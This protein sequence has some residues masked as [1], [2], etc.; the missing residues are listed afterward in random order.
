MKNNGDCLVIL[1]PQHSHVA[2]TARAL[3]QVPP[4]AERTLSNSVQAPSSLLILPS[5]SL[6]ISCLVTVDMSC[7]TKGEKKDTPGSNRFLVVILTRLGLVLGPE[8]A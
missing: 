7:Y 5:S 1:G 6:D 4:R 3:Q 2:P 8:G